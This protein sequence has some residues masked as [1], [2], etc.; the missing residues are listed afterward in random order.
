LTLL[1]LLLLLVFTFI[2]LHILAI[3]KW[4]PGIGWYLRIFVGRIGGRVILGLAGV[5]WV[6][7]RVAIEV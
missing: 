1:R 4:L 5:V 2:V 6:D 3:A 7:E